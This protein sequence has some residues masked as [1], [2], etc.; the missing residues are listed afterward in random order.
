MSREDPPICVPTAHLNLM[1]RLV[2]SLTLLLPDAAAV[3]H[4]V[5]RAQND[6]GESEP[7]NSGA[8]ACVNH[9]PTKQADR[10]AYQGDPGSCI[11][12][13]HLGIRV[14]SDEFA[15]VPADVVWIPPTK[16]QGPAPLSRKL[17]RM[18]FGR[19]TSERAFV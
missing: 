5:E 15:Y 13:Y 16:W 18:N 7:E 17:V 12:R 10:C 4:G 19:G 1:M 3:H 2:D 6:V 8:K 9:A 14:P 11:H